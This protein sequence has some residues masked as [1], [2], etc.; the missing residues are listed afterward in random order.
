MHFVQSKPDVLIIGKNPHHTSGPEPPKKFWSYTK[1]D[2]LH[3]WIQNSWPL[4]NTT[5]VDQNQQ[6]RNTSFSISHLNRV[7][8]GDFGFPRT[9]CQACLPISRRDHKKL[10]CLTGHVLNYGLCKEM[11]ATY[12]FPAMS[13]FQN[14]I[15]N[16]LKRRIWNECFSFFTACPRRLFGKAIDPFRIERIYVFPIMGYVALFWSLREST[17]HYMYLFVLFSLP[18]NQNHIPINETPEI[19]FLFLRRKTTS[20]LYPW[21]L[22]PFGKPST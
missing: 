4:N 20:W 5:T 22:F 18:S 17:N 11:R 2:F 9:S 15:W 21:A 7:C 13:A 6:Q 14:S 16:T 8:S 1:N 12:I 3:T 19:C 10:H